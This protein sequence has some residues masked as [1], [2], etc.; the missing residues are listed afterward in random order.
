MLVDV[1]LGKRKKNQEN[2]QKHFVSVEFPLNRV[3]LS[4]NMGGILFACFANLEPDARPVK[5]KHVAHYT[6][7]EDMQRYLK[8]MQKTL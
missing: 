7:S 6:K 4:Y 1:D 3:S 5:K 8:V 2:S